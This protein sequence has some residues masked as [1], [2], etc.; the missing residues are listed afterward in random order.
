EGITLLTASGELLECSPEQ[1][2]EL[3]KAAQVSLGMLGVIVKV[4]LRVVPA[5]Q[6]HFQSRREHISDILASL[7]ERKQEN[8]HFEFFWFPHTEW[9]QAKYLNEVEAVPQERKS[10]FW[11]DLNKVVLENG[12]YWL[13]SESCRVA[14]GLSSAMSNVSAFGVASIEETDY[15]HRLFATPR[16]VRF[17]EMEYNI[18]AEHLKIVLA[19]L[20]NYIER[21]KIRVHFPIECR[22]VHSDDIWLSPAYQRDSAYVAVHMYRGMPYQDYFEHA[23]EI[24]K[25]YDGRPHWGKMH[26]LAA[27]ELARRYPRWHDFRRIRAELDPNGLFMNDYLRQL[28]A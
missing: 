11:N 4:V 3:F 13:I 18:P 5:H 6:L 21:R 10:T 26:N 28:F 15:S 20:R 27:D 8:N 7:D 14:P 23:E 9:V 1:N 24:F 16:M 19:E 25:R 12:V 2:P 17:Q 22:F